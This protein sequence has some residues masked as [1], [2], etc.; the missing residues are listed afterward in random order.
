MTR[1]SR[2]GSALALVIAFLALGTV[3]SIVTPLFESPDEVWHYEYVRWLVEGHGLARPDEVGSAPWHQEG[4]QPPLYYLVA[5]AVTRSIPTDNAAAVIRY[6]PHAAMGEG[7]SAGNKNVMVHGA[8]DA[9][10]WQGVVFAGHM[11][12]FLSLLFGAVTVLAT[13]ATAVTI[14]PRS[15]ALAALAAGLVAFDPQFLFITSSVSNIGLVTAASAAGVWLSVRLVARYAVPTAPEGTSPAGGPRMWEL[16][17]LGA[18]AG[19]A[20]LTQ[21]SGLALTGLAGLALLIVAWRRRTPFL[22][23]V[24]W[25]AIMAAALLV[26]AGWWYARNLVLYR[27][28][29][30]LQAMFDVLPKR[31]TAPKLSELL[32][33]AEGVWRSMWAVF[34]WF[35]VLADQRVYALYSTLSVAGLAG[36]VL[37]RPVRRLARSRR[38]G[39]REAIWQRLLLLGLLALWV[40][41]MLL[42]V[43]KWTQMR[44][45]QGRLLFPA[46]S[47]AAVLLAFGLTGWAPR[48]LQAA[49]SGTVIAGL[50]VLAVISPFV[51]I[52]PAYAR[53]ALLPASAALPNPVSAVFGDEIRLAGYQLPQGQV[54]PGEV[55]DLTLYW[56]AAKLPAKDYSIFVHLVDEYGIVQA[57]SDSY[58]AEGSLATTDWPLTEIVPDRHRVALPATT[59]GPAR[60]SIVVGVYDYTTGARLRVGAQDEWQIGEVDVAPRLSADGI[61]NPVDINFD[62]QL[63][64]VGFSSD[65]RVMHPG[66]TLNLDLW[67]RAETTPRQ[68]Y[69]AFAHLVLAPDAVWAGQDR[70]PEASGGPTSHWLPGATAVDRHVLALPPEAPA[71]VYFIEIGLYGP[72]GRLAVDGS[73]KGIVLGYV[74]VE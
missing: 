57:Q 13:Y 52:Q 44:Y 5:A 2:V 39:P 17:L 7:L 59:T 1:R 24:R 62:N 51:W 36:I 3:Y 38:P 73:D 68:D 10:P 14:F 22:T 54:Q 37:A 46:L 65:R 74:K 8:A 70:Q 15:P 21:L 16:L 42:A 11:A 29:L 64:L 35:N 34:G 71:G 25:G 48:R 63:A 28:P 32:A 18:L 47:S 9:W 43:L 19:I 72:E 53:P 31:A 55:L 30:G 69:S 20:A 4:S 40:L 61:P 41:V 12:R 23:L 33:R 49:L 60:L 50:A 26:V 67:W 45:P 27:D 6:N 66:E 58:P 56:Q